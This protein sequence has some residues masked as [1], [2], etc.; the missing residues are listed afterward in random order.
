MN[1]GRGKRLGVI[2]WLSV[3]WIALLVFFALFRDLLPIRDPDE[4]GI[5]TR[6]VAQF[7]GPGFNALFGGDERGRDLFS[8]VVYGTRPALVLGFVVTILAATIG[9]TIGVLSGYLRGPFDGV[10]SILIDISL[11]FPVLVLLIAVRATFGNSLLVF[12][13]LFTATGI[14]AY[15]RIVRGAAL[16]WSS[17][18]SSTLR[19]PW[20][21]PP[22]ACCG[23]NSHQTSCCPF[24]LLP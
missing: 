7:E 12:I 11:A 9:S 22:G 3:G 2:F 4:L 17:A 14:P 15:A 8:R 19:W 21:Q 23:V 10:S 16:F 13:L 6:E 20:V 18:S 5:R 1:R 24:F